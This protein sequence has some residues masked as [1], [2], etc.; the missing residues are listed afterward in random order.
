MSEEMSDERLY[1]LAM[2]Y[3]QARIESAFDAHYRPDRRSIVRAAGVE[4]LGAIVFTS[5]SAGE[6]TRSFDA[7]AIYAVQKALGEKAEPP[8]LSPVPPPD[9][10]AAVQGYA[11]VFAQK[12]I[13]GQSEQAQSALSEDVREL[14]KQ[15]AAAFH[16]SMHRG[17]WSGS[18][19][20]ER[21]QMA[22][23]N[24]GTWSCQRDGATEKPGE[25]GDWLLVVKAGRDGR[26][27]R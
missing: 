16:K 27:R 22:T 9:L 7:I 4:A 6:Y 3:L 5:R 8:A 23:Y 24:G 12:W 19:T 25:S 21:G 15:E 10:L 2:T 14:V 18:R 26:D 17:V 13:E 20:Y 1:D 11:D